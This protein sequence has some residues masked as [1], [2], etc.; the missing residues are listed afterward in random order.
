MKQNQVQQKSDP[1]WNAWGEL[2]ELDVKPCFLCARRPFGAQSSAASCW[3]CSCGAPGY[4]GQY[5]FGGGGMMERTH[6]VVLSH[7]DFDGAGGS[8]SK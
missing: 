4:G 6:L 5:A 7:L 1:P 3:R 8:C 2:R